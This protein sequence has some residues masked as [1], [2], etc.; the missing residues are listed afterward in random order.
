MLPGSGVFPGWM[1]QQG[2]L[3]SAISVAEAMF[4]GWS[5]ARLAEE[6]KQ[7]YMQGGNSYFSSIWNWFDLI[8]QCL[9]VTAIVIRAFVVPGMG[10]DIISHEEIVMTTDLAQSLYALVLISLYTRFIDAL[11]FST[12][13]GV[14]T[15]ILKQ[16]IAKDLS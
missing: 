1:H 5:G 16:I 12:S 4:W 7:V 9:V 14:L 10:D 2:Y 8:A 15:I 3:P 6:F 13:M 11:T